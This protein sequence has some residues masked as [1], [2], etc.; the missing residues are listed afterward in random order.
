MKY[1]EQGNE[2]FIPTNLRLGAGYEFIF[3]SSNSLSATF[4]IN[5]LLKK[6]NPYNS[7]V[8]FVLIYKN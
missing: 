2:S 5:K 3:D 4:E 6:T 7:K 8:V 1:A